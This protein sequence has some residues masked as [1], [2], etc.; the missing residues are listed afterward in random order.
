MGSI[1]SY[2]KCLITRRWFMNSYRK[3]IVLIKQKDGVYLGS[4]RSIEQLHLQLSILLIELPISV[5]VFHRLIVNKY[6]T[7]ACS[8]LLK[9][10]R[11]IEKE[12]QTGQKSIE[13]ERGALL[14]AEAA[15]SS[16]YASFLLSGQPL[17][18]SG[19]LLPAGLEGI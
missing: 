9:Q 8:K 18:L 13:R 5:Y 14:Q 3:P 19:K 10:E 6:L 7:M 15:C 12:E 4:K 2:L 11:E 17:L 1:Y 16:A